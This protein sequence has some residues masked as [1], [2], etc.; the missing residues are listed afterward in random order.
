VLEAKFV[1]EVEIA[2]RNLVEER[3]LKQNHRA[4]YLVL[5][6]SM[7]PR[8]RIV[9]LRLSDRVLSSIAGRSRLVDWGSAWWDQRGRTM[10]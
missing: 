6:S 9:V 4:T 1:E 10:A 3:H 8:T 7:P 5:V 2:G